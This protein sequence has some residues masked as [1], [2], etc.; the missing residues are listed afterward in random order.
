MAVL[1]YIETENL[2]S[3]ICSQYQ[4]GLREVQLKKR[5]E[6]IKTNKATGRPQTIINRLID[7]SQEYSLDVLNGYIHSQDSHYTNKRFLNGF[8]DFLFPLLEFLLDIRETQQ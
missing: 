7:P 2:E 8:W 4:C 5:L 3:T 1:K 6:F